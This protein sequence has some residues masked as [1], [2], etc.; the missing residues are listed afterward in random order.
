MVAFNRVVIGG[1]LAS[2]AESFSTSCGFAGDGEQPVSSP[3]LLAQWA[4]DIATGLPAELASSE[5]LAG[6]SS[7]GAI[8]EVRCYFYASET[9]PASAV[10]VSPLNLAGTGS[11]SRPT[12]VAAVLSLSTG[13]AG[14]RYRGRMYWPALGNVINTTGRFSSTVT[15]AL[16]Q[17]GSDLLTFIATAAPSA[18]PLIP[19]VV[20]RTGGFVTP[21]TEV[22]VG[23]VPDTQRSRRDN[24]DEVYATFPV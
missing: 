12:S 24:L 11:P 1:T 5:M 3:D 7:T 23:D 17:G 10:G 13:L 19:V 16:A 20:S 18:A 14:R 9:A 22:R 8:R 6:V 21:V 2:G 15:A 4:A